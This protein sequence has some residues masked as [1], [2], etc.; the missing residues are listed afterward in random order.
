MFWPNQTGS[1]RASNP[2]GHG[3]QPR[4]FRGTIAWQALHAPRFLFALQAIFS[5]TE[6]IASL[7]AFFDGRRF[8]KIDLTRGLVEARM[9]YNGSLVS[10]ESLDLRPSVVVSSGYRQAGSTIDVDYADRSARLDAR[11]GF[12]LAASFMVRTISPKRCDKGKA[13]RSSACLT[14]RLGQRASVISRPCLQE[15]DRVRVTVPKKK[16]LFLPS[17]R[18]SS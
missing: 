7:L 5:P 18:D 17:L 14:G 6:W 1:C 2:R 16:S 12:R 15:L 4:D 3:I 9:P 8:E 11:D 10:A 13:A